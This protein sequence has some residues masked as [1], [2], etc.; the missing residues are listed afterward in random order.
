MTAR[1]A[2]LFTLG[3]FVVLGCAVWAA[4]WVTNVLGETGAHGPVGLVGAIPF[5]I[6]YLVG[7]LVEAVLLFR[8]RLALLPTLIGYLPLGLLL[9]AAFGMLLLSMSV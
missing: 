2:H 5:L 4:I 8:A 1:A 9:L 7:A 6:L 3:L